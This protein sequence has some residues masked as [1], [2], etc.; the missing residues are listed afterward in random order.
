M[1]TKR[2]RSLSRLMIVVQV[3][4]SVILFYLIDF[5]FPH[6]GVV[7][8]EK[9]FFISQIALIWS[10][11]FY[12]FHLGVIFRISSFGSMIKGY[13][14][15]IGIG[16]LVLF[17]EIELIRL[18]LGHFSYHFRHIILFCLVNLTV[19]VIFKLSFYYLMRYYRRIGRNSRSVIIV[20]DDSN[21]SFLQ[22][23]INARDWGYRLHAI[24]SPDENIRTSFPEAHVIKKQETLKTYITVNTIDDIF[25]C[26]PVT[27]ERYNVEQLI[28]DAEEIG[29][30]THIMQ[31]NIS[32]NVTNRPTHSFITHQI[33]SP[34]YINLKIKELFDVVFSILVVVLLSP[35]FGLI[36]LLIKMEDGGPVFF[37]QERI[38]LNGRR[39]NCYK[40]RSM[41]VNAEQ[42][43]DE[44]KDKNESDGP[45]FKIKDDPRITKLGKILRKTSMDELPQFLNVIKGEMSIVGPRP[46]LLREVKQYERSQLRRLSMK[47]GITC[48]WQVWGRNKVSFEEWMK[49]DL[50]YIDNWSIWLDVK[51]MIAT[52]GVVIK[53]N[54]R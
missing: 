53:A 23:F 45:T 37:Q 52:I 31:E 39:F 41:V 9:W 4:I 43:I 13:M 8:Y 49:M 3:A 10:L 2:E 36:A 16:G 40:F 11:L 50:E 46:P 26:L 5:F 48:K 42:L 54:G 32:T 6:I 30:I 28:N 17:L 15:T 34:R 22:S 20:T 35:L 21:L 7:S 25:Y 14:V 51:L 19:L 18:T 33:T 27:D 1:I 12:K 47:P 29:I 38:G 44:L 24:V